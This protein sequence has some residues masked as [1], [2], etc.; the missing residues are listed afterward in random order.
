MAF[1]SGVT[2]T[3]CDYDDYPLE[4]TFCDDW[5]RVLLR[6]DCEQEPEN[7][8]RSCERSVAQG[9]CFP[10]QEQL[11]SCYDGTKPSD[12]ACTGSGFQ[13]TP[14][15]DETLCQPERDALIACAYPSVKQCLDVCRAVETAVQADA[16]P[17]A[18]NPPGRACPSRDIPCDSI[19]W[20]LVAG[21]AGGEGDD[22]GASDAGSVSSSVA[23]DLIDC[24]LGR[25][26]ACRSGEV[27]G[28]DASPGSLQATWGTAL[29]DCAEAAGL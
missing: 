24:A 14:R 10:L 20:L 17:D 29:R 23:S 5:C 13:T 6:A 2:L 16:G 22:A 3:N 8:V 18:Q 4:P 1:W 27:D 9:D 11:L 28:G 21:Y 15:P 25:A 7:C 12:W 19:C 26:D